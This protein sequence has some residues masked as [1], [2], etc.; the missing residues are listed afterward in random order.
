MAGDDVEKTANI[1][2]FGL[3]EFPRMVFGLR[4]AAQTYQ[5]FMNRVLRGLEFCFLY[6][7]DV[8]IA[9]DNVDEHLVHLDS[10][11]ERL[12]NFG[13]VVNVDKC[14]FLNCEVNF[15]GHRVAKNGVSPLPEKVADNQNFPKPLIVCELKRFLG[16]VNF[17]RRFL[18]GAAKVQSV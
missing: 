7:D 8:L 18:P 4:Y 16:V 15:L 1:T 9:S 5:R 14:K 3:F 6:I 17:Y 2:P 12:S 10:V 11:F 13:V